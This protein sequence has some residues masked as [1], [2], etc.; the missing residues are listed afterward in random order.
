MANG[1]DPMY[2]AFK[3]WQNG[4]FPNPY[5]NP[6]GFHANGCPIVM[7]LTDE[8]EKMR[9][10]GD[11]ANKAKIASEEFA[12]M[13]REAIETPLIIDVKP[14]ASSRESEGRG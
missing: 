2:D 4:Q 13:Y 5:T 7:D 6:N 8:V 10:T 1:N 14:V 3:Y 9:V 11:A 12:R